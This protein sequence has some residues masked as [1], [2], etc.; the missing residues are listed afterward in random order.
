[1]PELKAV[2]EEEIAREKSLSFARFMEMA[3]YHPELGY[4]SKAAR[5]DDYYTNADVHPVFGE[6]VARFLL[7]EFKASLNG[8]M[9][10]RVAELGAGEGKLAR[11]ILQS[12]KEIAPAAYE[13]CLYICVEKSPSRRAACGSVAEAFPGRVSVKEDFDFGPDKFTGVVLS[14]EFF[15]ALPFHR[16]LQDKGTLYEIRV[17]K[18]LEETLLPAVKEL[19]DYF[20][21][22]GHFPKDGAR[23]EAQVSA[24]EW[25]GKIGRALKRGTVLSIDYGFEARELLSDIRPEGTAICHYRHAVNRD[26]YERVGEQDITAHVNFSALVKEGVKWGLASSLMTQTHF[27]L[28][29]G[30]E[31]A[32]EKI[33]KIT[34]PKARLRLSSAI[35]TLIHPGSLGGAFKVLLQKKA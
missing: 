18:E 12:L 11:H 16:V 28:E 25:M 24:V 20:E 10:L 6:I 19:R 32:V 29:N 4:Y 7:N 22:L 26:F 1:M 15:D 3:L 21:A 17:N 8:V 27:V 35:K 14:N 31:K 23:A 13:K 34:D 2:I 30:F 33:E 9:A 5:Q